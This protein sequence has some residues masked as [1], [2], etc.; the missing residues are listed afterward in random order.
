MGSRK[1]LHSINIHEQAIGSDGVMSFDLAVNPLSVL[2]LVLRPLNDTTT[3]ADFASYMNIA[4]A[5]NRIAVL[6][7]GVSVISMTGRDAA[8]LAFFRH[9]VITMQANHDNTTNERRSF[10]LP[11][12]LGNEAYSQT[13]CFPASKRGELQLEIDF[14]IAATG[15]DGLRF[16]METIELPGA[17]PKEYERKVQLSATFGATGLNDVEL[18]LGNLNRGLLLF[19]T[20]PFAGA[21]PAPT[22]GR[23]A[24]YIDNEQ[25]N[26]SAHDFEVAHMMS[27]LMGGQPPAVDEHIH[28]TT[29]DGNAGTSI[30]TIGAPHH[31]GSSG[32]W[33]NYCYINFDPTGDDMYSLETKGASRFHIENNA[34]TA[35]A[36]RV[37]PVERIKV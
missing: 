18:P 26:Y 3:L 2:L 10:I 22:W 1:F 34:E 8:A 4:G 33:E 16:G 15:Y 30:P 35:N 9:G 11:I 6:H 21:S 12:W 5:M 27:T 13:S 14:D 7:N 24:T 17:K 31:V 20:T 23:I 36:F 28:G 32:G 25:V 29:V 37:I 19:G